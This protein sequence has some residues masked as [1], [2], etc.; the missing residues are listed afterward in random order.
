M[1]ARIAVPVASCAL[2]NLAMIENVRRAEDP[3]RACPRPGP[4]VA[5]RVV[6]HL[7]RS[8]CEVDETSKAFRQ[9]PPGKP[10]G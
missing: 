4:R 3:A 9:R 5:E 10:S 1:A 2:R 6:E 7:E 8:N